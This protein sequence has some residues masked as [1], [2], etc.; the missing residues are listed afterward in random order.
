MS[1]PQR[2]RHLKGA[3]V[4]CLLALGCAACG[5]FSYGCGSEKATIVRPSQ[6]AHSGRLLPASKNG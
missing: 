4:V 2:V 6:P 3:I 5:G 1:I